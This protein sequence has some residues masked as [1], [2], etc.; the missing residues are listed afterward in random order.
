VHAAARSEDPIVHWRRRFIGEPF[1]ALAFAETVERIMSTPRNEVTI[2]PTRRFATLGFADELA[3]RPELL[4][5]Y[6]DAYGPADDA[7][8]ML[9]APGLAPNQLLALAEQALAASGIGDARVP[10][11]LLVPMPGSPEADNALAGRADALLSEWPGV[12]EI[13][14]LPRFSASQT[15]RT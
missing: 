10:D 11:I 9:W 13:G 2:D 6:A 12:G 14:K 1:N 15:A 4:R 3:E 5:S 7:T 8:L